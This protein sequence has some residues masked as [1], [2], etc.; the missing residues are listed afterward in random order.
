MI[1]SEHKT[2]STTT[3]VLIYAGCV[4]VPTDFK[5]HTEELSILRRK[6]NSVVN[7]IHVHAISICLVDIRLGVLQVHLHD[8]YTAKYPVSCLHSAGHVDSD[9]KFLYIVTRS[10]N[11]GNANTIKVN[12]NRGEFW[13]FIY[14]RIHIFT[15]I[16]SIAPFLSF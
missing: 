6:T 9:E 16:F 5:S 8:T 3:S 10:K 12:E 1:S 13:L 11:K 4:S 7:K 15:Q 2:Y 14:I